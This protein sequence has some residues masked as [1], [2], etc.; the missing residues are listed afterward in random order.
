[1][2]SSPTIHGNSLFNA[3]RFKRAGQLA[4]SGYSDGEIAGDLGISARTLRR[5]RSRHPHLAKTID[6]GRRR[7]ATL[8]HH[9]AFERA[10]GF[11]AKTERIIEGAAGPVVCKI[12]EY[13]PPDTAAQKW[14]LNHQRKSA[15]HQQKLSAFRAQLAQNATLSEDIAP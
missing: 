1:M 5:W 10:I 15:E 8:V 13:H 6:E 12:T 14:W 2:A 9:A 3:E 4:A 11:Q 7:A